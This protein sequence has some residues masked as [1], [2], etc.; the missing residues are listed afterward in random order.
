MDT[1]SAIVSLLRPHDCVAAGFDAG[2]DW[3][4]QF[5]AHEGIKCNA[6]LKGSCW[7]TVAGETAV[8]LDAGDCVILP[9]GRPFL[10]SSK[11]MKTGRDAQV[12]YAP[13]RHGGTAVYGTGG[14]FFMSGARFLLSGPTAQILLAGLPAMIAVRPGPEQDTVRWVLDQLAAELRNPRPGGPLTITHL[15]HILL[16]QVM[17][18]HLSSNDSHQIGWLAGLSDTRIAPAIRAM[19]DDPA[20]NWTVNSLAQ[21]AGRSRTSFAVHFR[22]VTG[23]AP[24]EYLTQWRMLVAA[25]RL[26]NA[27][28]SIATIAANVGYTSEST[29]G[30]AFKRIMGQAPR[31][32]A[33]D[34]KKRLE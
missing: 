30:A 6:V 25:D 33:R 5:E 4:I 9:Q 28:S 16:L 11:P 1:L 32:F 15:S 34:Q 24:I 2:G 12:L 29:F 14:D 7:V 3:S 20:Q 27:Q 10:L 8:R 19:H 23:Q 18:N 17:R 26:Q 31:S 22:Q 21:V 13:V